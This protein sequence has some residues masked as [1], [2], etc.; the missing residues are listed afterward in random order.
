MVPTS[1]AW[2]INYGSP[3]HK[4]HLPSNPPLASETFPSTSG[5]SHLALYRN[6]SPQGPL[7]NRTTSRQRE[8]MYMHLSPVDLLLGGLS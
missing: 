5:Q 8:K 1:S 3:S 6:S 7:G 4:I 2:L